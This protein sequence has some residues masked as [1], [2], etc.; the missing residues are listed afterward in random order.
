[1][2]DKKIRDR[3]VSGRLLPALQLFPWLTLLPLL[4]ASPLWWI[5]IFGGEAGLEV[6]ALW[7]AAILGTT[8]IAANTVIWMALLTW[9]RPAVPPAVPTILLL[10]WLFLLPLLV[11]VPLCW[12]GV[13]RGS[14]LALWL[15]SFLG[16]VSIGTGT[17]ACLFTLNWEDLAGCSRV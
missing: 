1:M 3:D 9:S 5:A 17:G 2:Q 14:S 4:A 15:G 6:P 10:P 8:V 12:V 7:I 16:L 13:G 11:V